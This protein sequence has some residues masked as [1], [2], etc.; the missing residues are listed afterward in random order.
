MLA[1]REAPDLLRLCVRVH[2]G[3]PHLQVGRGGRW[4]GALT[5]DR[6]YFKPAVLV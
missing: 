2:R 1:P 4:I 3:S 6:R 5:E